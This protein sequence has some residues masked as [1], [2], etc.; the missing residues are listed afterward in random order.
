M[1]QNMIQ[2]VERYF[3]FSDGR[4]AIEGLINFGKWQEL[5]YIFSDKGTIRGNHYHKSTKEAFIILSGRINVT[6]QKVLNG[7]FV[8]KKKKYTVIKG[9]VFVIEPLVNHVFHV[10]DPAEWLNLLSCKIDQKI[11]DIFRVQTNI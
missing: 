9:Q 11:P 2:F 8:G 5:N 3:V 7:K 10:E 4:G 6:L 1:K